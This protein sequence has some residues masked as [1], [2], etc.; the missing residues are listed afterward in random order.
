[1][2][3]VF[4][5]LSHAPGQ[6]LKPVRVLA[7]GSPFGDDAVAW[8]VAAGLREHPEYRER[9]GGEISLLE[10][11]R[12]GPGLI[13]FLR[14]DGFIVLVDAVVDGGCPGRV[15]RL[16]RM[17]Q[18]T[19]LGHWSSHGLG[20]GESLRMAEALGELTAGWVLLGITIDPADAD[21]TATGGLSQ[22][23]AGAVDAAVRGLV[24]EL[25]AELPLA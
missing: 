14:G 18:V 9:L 3:F 13:E 1:M 19:G 24:V 15:L 6:P 12:P 8:A 22:P 11:D 23:V 20:V 5:P 17:D 2:H 16:D 25:Q 10:C 7:I 21:Q 4:D